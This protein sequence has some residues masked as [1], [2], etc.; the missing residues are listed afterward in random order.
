MAARQILDNVWLVASGSDAQAFTDVH[1][2]HCYLVWNGDSGFLIDTGTGLGGGRWLDNVAEICPPSRLGA[3]YLT[4][5]HADHAGAAAD[6][7]EAGLPVRAHAITAEA[8]RD[9]DE[10]QTQLRRARDAGVYPPDLRLRRSNPEILQPGSLV[11]HGAL[12]LQVIDAPGHCDGHLV[13]AIELSGQLVL[14]TGD[15]LFAGSRVSMQPIP[16]CRLDRYAETVARLAELKADVLLPGHG[17]HVLS[18]GAQ[19]VDRATSAF[20][21]LIPPPNMLA[22]W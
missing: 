11:R 10:E 14:F 16:D 20:Q 7:E 5:C 6:A 19:V 17:D 21:R 18:D 3:V 2:C 22:P 13:F 15:C 8:L 4:H 9:A 1:D 12:T